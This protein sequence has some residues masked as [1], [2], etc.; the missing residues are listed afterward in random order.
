VNWIHGHLHGVDEILTPLYLNDNETADAG[1]HGLAIYTLSVSL[2]LSWIPETSNGAVAGSVCTPCGPLARGFSPQHGEY[3]PLNEKSVCFG[4][5]PHSVARIKWLIPPTF[6]RSS[7]Q[8]LPLE[9]RPHLC[10][11]RRWHLSRVTVRDGM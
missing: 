1:V 8:V 10:R 4:T 11:N 7:Y 5:R 9:V 2:C 6:W 3:T